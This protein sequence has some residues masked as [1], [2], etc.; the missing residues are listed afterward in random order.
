MLLGLS[1][2]HNTV[3]SLKPTPDHARRGLFGL[4]HW[5]GLGDAVRMLWDVPGACE[6]GRYWSVLLALSL[7]LG[8]LTIHAD[9][10]FL[11][12][13]LYLGFQCLIRLYDEL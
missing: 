6:N 7:G 8:L 3:C 12:Y 4:L 1:P 11:T 5:N 9:L 13:L 10:P 2:T